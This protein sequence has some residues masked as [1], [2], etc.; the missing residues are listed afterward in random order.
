[1]CVWRVVRRARSRLR[2]Q[3]FLLQRR[4]ARPGRFEDL[5]PASSPPMETFVVEELV[6]EIAKASQD[7]QQLEQE[8]LMEGSSKY[9]LKQPEDC[10]VFA[11][12]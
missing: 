8:A 3:L 10:P 12:R 6:A 2:C 11:K 7:L 5:T 1:M 9:Y 4:C